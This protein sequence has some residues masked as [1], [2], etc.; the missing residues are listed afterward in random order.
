MMAEY[1]RPTVWLKLTFFPFFLYSLVSFTVFKLRLHFID[2]LVGNFRCY[3]SAKDYNRCK[4]T[5]IKI[6]TIV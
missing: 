2:P 1:V 5:K 4:K 6:T 3:S